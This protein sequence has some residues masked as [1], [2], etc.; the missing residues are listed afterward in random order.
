MK[1]IMTRVI[2]LFA[3]WFMLHVIFISADGLIDSKQPADL[4]VILGNKVEQDGKPSERLRAR[5][6]K[7]LELYKEGY[8]NKI[9]VSGGV[10]KEGF[11]E[12]QVMKQYLVEKGIPADNILTDSMGLNT[13]MTAQNTKQMINGIESQKVMVITQFYHISRTKLAFRKMGF[14]E[15]YSAHA[16]YF[17]WRD[18]YSLFREFFAYYQY[19][20]TDASHSF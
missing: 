7:A 13:M 15:V 17:E 9:L 6:E 19:F 14:Q 16:N 18:I 8:L 4:G 20:L 1:R 5:L 11:D 2:W 12:A 10:G 3:L